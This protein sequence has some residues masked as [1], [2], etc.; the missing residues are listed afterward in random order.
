MHSDHKES[1]RTFCAM[2]NNKRIERKV[3]L[4]DKLESAVGLIDSTSTEIYH[5]QIEPQE[6]NFSGHRHFHAIHT[7][8]VID[9]AGYI[10]YAEARGDA[11]QFTINWCKW[12]T[13]LPGRLLDLSKSTPNSYA[14]Y[15]TTNKLKTRTH[16]GPFSIYQIIGPVHW[17]TGH[18]LFFLYTPAGQVDFLNSS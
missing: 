8:V 15:N 5:P 7:Q 14:I 4:M 10:C 13:T 12:T 9:N 18:I 17:Y 16:K 2:T 11:K 1:I 6:L 3:M